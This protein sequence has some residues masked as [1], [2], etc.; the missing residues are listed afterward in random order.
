MEGSQLRFLSEKDSGIFNAMNKGIRLSKGEYLYFLN[1]GDVLVNSKA[2][3]RVFSKVRGE[4]FLY[5]DIVLETESQH[6]LR[7]YPEEITYKYWLNEHLCHQASIFKKSIFEKH[8][9]YD[10]M[11]RYTA[12]R[13][14]F[15]KIYS[16]PGLVKRHIS[17]VIAIYNLM[18]VSA[19]ADL[20][21]KVLAEIVKIDQKYLPTFRSFF[22]RQ[23]KKL[24]QWVSTVRIGLIRKLLRL[25]LAPF[26]I[27]L[28]DL[29]QTVR[30]EAL[31]NFNGELPRLKVLLLNNSDSGGGASVATLRLMQGLREL[32]VNA[33]MVVTEKLGQNKSVV[34]I[35]EKQSLRRIP[36]I[37]RFQLDRF[38]NFVLRLSLPKEKLSG[39]FRTFSMGSWT[40]IVQTVK[41]Y[42]PDVVHLN[43][44]CGHLLRPETIAKINK[45]IVWTMH[46]MWPFCGYEHVTESRRFVE[47]YTR[48]NK[49]ASEPGFDFSRWA[50][51]RKR[52]AFKKIP[53]ALIVAPSTWMHECAQESVLFKNHKV[54][55]AHN[56]LDP[57]LFQP[58][59]KAKMREILNLPQDK[60]IILF[61]AVD[62]SK[63]ANKN[64]VELEKALRLLMEEKKRDEVLMVIFG[65]FDESL[66]EKFPFQTL[67]VGHQAYP[68][69][70]AALYAAADVMVVPSK[71]ESFGQAA[72]ESLACGTP[73]VCFNTSGLRD[74]VEHQVNGYLAKKCDPNDL[75]NGILWVLN[76]KERAK[77]LGQNGREKVLKNFT[78]QKQAQTYMKIYQEAIE[79][80]HKRKT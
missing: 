28:P 78:I 65:F 27:P 33:T 25:F 29:N 55:T 17:E 30:D 76:D 8:G 57:Q 3:E 67:V 41:F 50:W 74:I 70:L 22:Y 14:Y 15:L 56:G 66:A 44:V 20:R 7:S 49:P 5:C 46:D 34:R 68:P 51:N 42:N 23:E 16:S 18:G 4:D 13:E 48:K 36:E 77:T 61:G 21:S 26:L 47:G 60:Q 6:I 10:E 59:D 62:A 43:W 31:P 73:V 1:A 37:I 2:L 24:T 54:F 58:R 45:P 69:V 63:D 35:A 39:V 80:F 12:D 53:Q 32:N 19:R 38:L 79:G 72:S 64:F 75:K 71:I 9:Y 52:K 40:D 11:Y